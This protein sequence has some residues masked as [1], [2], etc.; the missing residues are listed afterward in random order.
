MF[1]SHVIVEHVHWLFGRC[2]TCETWTLTDAV[3]TVVTETHESMQRHVV[4][5]Q[6]WTA[7]QYGIQVQ[8]DDGKW[9]HASAGS[10]VQWAMWLDAFQDLA[11]PPKPHSPVKVQFNDDVAV[12]EIPV[13]SDEEKALLFAPDPVFGTGLC[14]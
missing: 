8:T 11:P 4:C 7:I 9:L 13:L 1:T 3:L 10:K 5:G 12:L 2:F 6:A 14:A